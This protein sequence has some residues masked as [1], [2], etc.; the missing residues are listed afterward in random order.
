ML[1]GYCSADSGASHPSRVR[2]LKFDFRES[3]CARIRVAPFAGAWIEMCS[4][5]LYN[6][7]IVS[8]PS[9]V[10]GLKYI[11][12]MLQNF[13]NLSHPSRVRGLKLIAAYF[14]LLLVRRTLR[15]CVD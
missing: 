15:G 1:A 5:P 7:G 9:R 6:F 14:Q 3:F 10:R 8:H 2:G 13:Q 11:Q 4:R 12:N